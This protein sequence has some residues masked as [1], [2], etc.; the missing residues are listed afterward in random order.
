MRPGPHQEVGGAHPVLE[1]YRPQ[2]NGEA[3]RL[4]QFVLRE[5]AY[6]W[7]YGNSAHRTDA[8]ADWPSRNNL[9]T[10]HI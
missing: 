7:T 9:L 4:I 6:G 3:E 2:T 5:R 8:A 10:L 1:R